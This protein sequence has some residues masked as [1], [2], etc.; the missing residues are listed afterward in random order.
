MEKKLD[1]F[2]LIG[3]SKEGAHWNEDFV[4]ELTA[5]LKPH[6]VV[7]CDLIGA[8]QFLNQAS[9]TN[10]S[11]T[12][13]QMRAQ[14]Q[15]QLHPGHRRVLVAI[16]LGAMVGIEWIRLFPDDFESIV[17]VNSSIQGVS[18]LT[19][20]VQPNAMKK[21]LQ[22]FFTP[23]VEQKEK[24]IL[25]LC[26]NHPT[27]AE[28]I[29]PKW[30]QIARARPVKWQNLIRQAIAGATFKVPELPKVPRLI[31]AAKGDRLA[32]YSCSIRL[33]EAWG[34][35][36]HGT[37]K[38]FEEPHIGHAFHVDAPDVLA[39]EIEAWIHRKEHLESAKA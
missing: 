11:E 14:Y 38:V 12:A 23:S 29:Y 25:E 7:Q 18:P 33:H 8:G 1:L 30:V 4:Q 34:G 15:G 27:N 28:K 37:I 19:K 5:R 26:S 13:R 9:P 20:R 39:S 36:A 24:L 31:M 22:V 6:S 17:V 16:S 10:I 35:D 3:L 21:I 32:H 2:L